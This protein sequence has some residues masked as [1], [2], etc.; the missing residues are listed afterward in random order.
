[1]K[2]GP[3]ITA[4]RPLRVVFEALRRGR[5]GATPPAA[6]GRA[7]RGGLPPP[8]RSA[9]RPGPAARNYDRVVREMLARH[10]VR[11][12]RWRSSM[13]GV[14]MLARDRRTGE[15]VRLIEA[16]YPRGPVSASIFLHEIGHHAIGLGVIRPRCLEELRAWRFAIDTMEAEGIAVTDR[17]RARMDRSLRYAV[18]KSRRRGL[19]RLPG[20][21][22][23]YTAVAEGRARN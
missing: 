13:S 1:M 22:A 11:V 10:D 9:R 8:A 3:R 7:T 20:E 4:T 6:A 21:L 14:A 15:W 17:V 18:A 2:P 5:T 16:P 19:K 23:A 12:R